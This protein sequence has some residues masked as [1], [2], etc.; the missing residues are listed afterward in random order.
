MGCTYVILCARLKRTPA[1]RKEDRQR[2]RRDKK[3]LEAE[4]AEAKD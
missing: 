3:M 2:S 4:E 1:D